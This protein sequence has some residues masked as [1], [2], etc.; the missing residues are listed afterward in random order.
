VKRF[1][2]GV[3]RVAPRRTSFADH[4]ARKVIQTPV[5]N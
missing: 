2:R 5:G 3:E 4:A 1:A